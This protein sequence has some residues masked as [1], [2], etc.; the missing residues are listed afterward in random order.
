MNGKYYVYL[1]A[2]VLSTVVIG[3]P[4]QVNEL[5]DKIKSSVKHS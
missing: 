5:D 2:V 1:I 4:L 3:M